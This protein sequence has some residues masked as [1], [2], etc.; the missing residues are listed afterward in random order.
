MNE[1]YIE[2]YTYNGRPEFRKNFHD[3]MTQAKIR[4]MNRIYLGS[5]ND[6]Y[7]LLMILP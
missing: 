5:F 4:R 2:R 6:R 3:S 7:P 1:K